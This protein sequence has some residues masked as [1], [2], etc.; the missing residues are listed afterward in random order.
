M[1]TVPVKWTLENPECK[2]DASLIAL[3]Y[4]GGILCNDAFTTVKTMANGS[5]TSLEDIRMGRGLLLMRNF[6]APPV[7]VPVQRTISFFFHVVFATSSRSSWL[8]IRTF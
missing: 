8:E 2:S 5:L 4:S 7:A 1:V 3:Y 6:R